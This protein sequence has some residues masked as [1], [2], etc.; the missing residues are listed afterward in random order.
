MLK[1]LGTEAF[2]FGTKAETDQ[3]QLGLVLCDGFSGAAGSLHQHPF[4]SASPGEK[5]LS[6]GTFAG[7]H[8]RLFRYSAKGD[9]E[10][11]CL[12]PNPLVYPQLCKNIIQW[13]MKDQVVPV[14]A[15]VYTK[16]GMVAF[17]GDGGSGFNNVG[18]IISLDED[19]V[20]ERAGINAAQ[21][22]YSVDDYVTLTGFVPSLIE[23][24]KIGDAMRVLQSGQKTITEHKP[25]L[26]LI[27]SPHSE[28]AKFINHL[29]PSYQIYYSECGR[30]EFG[31][32]FAVAA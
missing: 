29:V 4:V 3:N 21:Y 20:G 11:H 27:G 28:I 24:G 30:R 22:A 26:I 16:S 9:F 17:V 18:Q 15:G 31:A 2:E 7:S 6:F 19:N 32:F 12:E 25:K 13:G 10:A 23:S 14:C 5:I 8:L 1:D